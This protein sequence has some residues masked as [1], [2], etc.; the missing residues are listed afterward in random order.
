MGAGLT[1]TEWAERVGV[2]ELDVREFR[3]S[4][5][6]SQEWFA[7]WL[8]VDPRTVRRW[9]RDGAPFVVRLLLWAFSR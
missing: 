7:E 1:P 5:G 6:M 9:E 2:A 8:G 3:H 4:A